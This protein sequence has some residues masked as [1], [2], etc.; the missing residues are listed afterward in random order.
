LLIQTNPKE[1]ESIFEVHVII[2]AIKSERKKILEKLTDYST[3]IFE[4]KL[5]RGDLQQP[6]GYLL[7]KPYNMYNKELESLK[8]RM[9]L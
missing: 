1:D 3:K 9:V 5:G 7:K 4:G 2:P 6:M 8:M